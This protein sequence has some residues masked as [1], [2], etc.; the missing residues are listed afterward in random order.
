MFAAFRFNGDKV[1]EAEESV[2]SDE[3][4]SKLSKE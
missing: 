1:D 4:F 2:E 3:D